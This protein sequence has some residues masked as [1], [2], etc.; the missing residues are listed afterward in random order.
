MPV[1]KPLRWLLRIFSAITLAFLYAPLIVIAIYAFNTTR[2][3]RWPPDGLTLSWFDK[4]LQNHG[5]R[6]A[7]WTSVQV[8]LAA[9]AIALVLGT[10][11]SYALARFEFFGRSA[12]SF[13]IILPIALP[14]IVTG[15]ALNATFTQVLHVDLALWTIVVAHA[16][17]CVVMVFNNVVAR[18]RRTAASLEDA[19]ADLGATPRRA[20]REV[21]YPQMRSA[22]IAGGLLAFALSFDEVIV[23]TFTAGDARTLPL[24]ILDN[25]SRPRNLPVVNVVATI[26]LILS[27]IPVWF[28]QRLSSDPVGV[29][30]AR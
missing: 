2:V 6:D 7:L 10:L 16:T 30:G 20:F 19:A 1:S 24:W 5:A 9:T 29:T 25:L 26:V 28:A 12:I 17:F 11:A 27:I 21:T 22:L 14:G 23:T 8:G 18:L 15:M 4:G 3:Q 13:L